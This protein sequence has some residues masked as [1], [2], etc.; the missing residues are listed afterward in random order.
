MKR[1][2]VLA[3]LWWVLL[4]HAS[5]QIESMPTAPVAAERG[6]EIERLRILV[7]ALVAAEEDL[8]EAK[9]RLAAAST[10]EEKAELG[11]ELDAQ[12]ERYL[13]LRG[14]FR[15]LASGIEES[16]YQSTAKEN[17][18]W[19]ENLEDI[20]API[21]N[22]VREL[23]SGPREMEA[24]RNDLRLWSERKKMSD[25]A[26]ERIGKLQA[27]A[28]QSSIE[29]EL[30][31][32]QKIWEDRADEAASRVQVLTQQIEEREKNSPTTWNAISSGI[33]G[34]WKSKG[35]NLVIA[36]VV[37]LLVFFGVK[38]LYRQLIRVS[39]MH[40]KKKN[41]LA[42]R[43]ADLMVEAASVLLA[44]LAA[45]LVF[46]LRGDWL[47]LAI[48]I[49]FMVGI[50]W[51]SKRAIP[52]Y[53]EQIK[54]ILN[55]GSVRQGERLVYDGIPWKVDRLNFYCDFSNPELAGGNLRLPVRDVMPLHSREADPKEPWFPTRCDDW[56]NLSD[57]VYGKVVN[58]TPEQVV[59]LILG[60]SRKTYET[61]A[62][63]ELSPENLSRGFRV[64]TVFGIDYSHQKIATT[65]VP[66]LF[67][68]RIEEALYELM[69]REVV[70]S[71][72][73]EFS[74][75]GASSL[76]YQVMA[77]FTGEMASRLNLLRRLIQKTCVDVCNEQ[78]WGIP[79]TQITVHQAPAVSG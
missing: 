50:G 9:A 62:F 5:A 3:L 26:L 13:Q 68:S 28:T 17:I 21:S 72:K 11:E 48:S 70:K 53:V 77:D 6:K 10:E 71:V 30:N 7:P 76:D 57:G 8:A 63:L 69:D 1:S 45:V 46:Y 22:G 2:L 32:T 38:G 51:T 59:V 64:S 44:I 55:I 33:K 56:V 67:Q 15:T 52:P 60:G 31:S 41:G 36:L 19:Q 73:V 42:A 39:P 47:L 58:Q 29:E 79:F 35:L 24:L 12:R 40:R 23:T 34:F 4:P 43:G 74:S 65:E 20:I 16:S 61:S 49:I 54:M 75:A 66:E 14:N 37:S 27:V 18:S 25:A 78:S